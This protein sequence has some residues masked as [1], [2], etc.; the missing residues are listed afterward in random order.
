MQSDQANNAALKEKVAGWSI[1]ASVAVTVGKALAGFATGSLA[2]LSDA[3]SSLL[4]IFATSV[5]FLAI[6]TA[7]KPAD[8]SHHYGHGKI[9]SLAALF[10]TAFLFLLAGVIAVEGANRL[11]T[12]KT[13]VEASWLA[14]AV[15]LASIV[16]DGWRWVVLRRTAQQ[17][18]GS[19]ALE[20]DAMHFASDL[21]NSVC[22]L[23][24]LGAV[25]YGY[26]W[27]DAAAAIG[28]ALFMAVA[29]FN[30]ARKTIAT[31]IDTAPKGISERL[32]NVAES[33]P[34]VVSVARARV[35][36]AGGQIFAEI[37]VQVSRT[38]PL[39]KVSAIKAQVIAAI[40]QDLPEAEVTVTTEPVSLNNET[41]ME[42][43]M[44][45]AAKRRL[46]VHHIMVQDVSGRLSLSL[47]LELDGRMSLSA[48]HQVASKLENAIQSELG[49]D[50]EIDTHIEPLR[51]GHVPGTDERES[52]VKSLAAALSAKAQAIGGISDLHSIRVRRSPEGLII[53]YH[54][55]FDPMMTV[56]RVHTLVDEL[57][58]SFRLDHPDVLRVVGHA[59]P[60]RQDGERD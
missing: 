19:E 43:V 42:R 12:Q 32:T 3:A 27:A 39:E 1:A 21:V 13:N 7:N 48:A 10:Q 9:E 44:L 2:L 28:T 40:A 4:D 25:A 23:A 14:V 20:A 46:P 33:V 35:R 49:A 29:G 34:G 60:I 22:V 5:T 55:R 47:D 52:V 50:I 16:I 15:I 24:A 53:N 11:L 18:R 57:E 38:L 31:L 56:S 54:C 6:R 37:L 41:I 51:V 36:P 58:W 45:I 17:V 26:K 59:E 30:L 8:E